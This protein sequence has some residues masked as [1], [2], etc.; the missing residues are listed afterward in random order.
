MTWEYP[1]PGHLWG[2]TQKLFPASRLVVGWTV[3]VQKKPAMYCSRLYICGRWFHKYDCSTFLV[4]YVGSQLK[5]TLSNIYVTMVNTE[6]WNYVSP[7][8]NVQLN[9][10]Y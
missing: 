2:I 6:V 4:I 1:G 8:S 5:S 9:K 7:V 10:T 3:K